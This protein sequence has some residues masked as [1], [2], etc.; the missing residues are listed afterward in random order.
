[1]KTLIKTLMKTVMKKHFAVMAMAL[2]SVNTWA[3]GAAPELTY[4]NALQLYWDGGVS[5]T[6]D[7]LLE[8][9]GWNGI[10]WA[11]LNL[12]GKDYSGVEFSFSKGLPANL[13]FEVYYVGDDAGS[14]K[15]QVDPEEGAT[16]VVL[17][18]DKDKTVNTIYIKTRDNAATIAL[19]KG[20]VSP[21]AT[22]G[23]TAVELRAGNGAVYTLGG[24]RT[25]K[26]SKG[27]YIINGKKTIV[28]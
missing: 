9:G 18:F 12:D 15:T 19:T 25:A 3:A 17:P 22:N 7:G 6:D 2:M 26:P 20:V 27:I 28:R 11:S 5:P 13:A 24:Q 14:G 4:A 21:R 10:R 8:I 23:V 1:M 16:T